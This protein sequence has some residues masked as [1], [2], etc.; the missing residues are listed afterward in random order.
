MVDLCGSG[1]YAGGLCEEIGGQ[2][3]EGRWKVAR[4]KAERGIAEDGKQQT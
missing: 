3:T 2:E 4:G 1:R